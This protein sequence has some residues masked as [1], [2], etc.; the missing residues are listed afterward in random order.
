MGEALFEGFDTQPLYRYVGDGT[1]GTYAYGDC[2]LYRI[3]LNAFKNATPKNKKIEE[4][5]W[6][7]TT[8][9]AI[10]R[11]GEVKFQVYNEWS[12][13]LLLGCVDTLWKE[14]KVLKCIQCFAS[15]MISLVLIGTL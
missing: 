4:A 8:H 10:G 5:A 11:A 7:I 13:D 2:D 9:D 6:I 3:M 15:Q 1:Y 14:S 12:Y